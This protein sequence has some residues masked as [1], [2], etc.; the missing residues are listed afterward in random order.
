[1]T[2]Q[3]DCGPLC[4]PYFE[5]TELRQLSSPKKGESVEHSD[6]AR[7]IPAW[8]RSTAPIAQKP[9]A[10]GKLPLPAQSLQQTTWLASRRFSCCSASSRPP[11]R[12]SPLSTV[13]ATA[14][15][16]ATAVSAPASRSSVSPLPGWSQVLDR[17]NQPR[18]LHAHG[19]GR[20]ALR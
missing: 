2:K 14:A 3:G 18:P 16:A 5:R 17:W 13:A 12:P 1:M 9:V 20:T 15:A 19:Q 4:G 10:T 11:L 6:M 7:D 8:G